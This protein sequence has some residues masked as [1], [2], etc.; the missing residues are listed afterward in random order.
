MSLAIGFLAGFAIPVTA[1]G[2]AYIIWGPEIWRS[3]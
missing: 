1:F 2:S 3:E